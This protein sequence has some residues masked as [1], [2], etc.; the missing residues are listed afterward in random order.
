MK[1]DDVD[2]LDLLEKAIVSMNLLQFRF[3][4]DRQ[5]DYD[6]MDWFIANGELRVY[7][8]GNYF[9][10][11]LV[12]KNKLNL[13]IGYAYA[14]CNDRNIENTNNCSVQNTYLN[15]IWRKTGKFVYCTSNLLN[16][17]EEVKLLFGGNDSYTF[18]NS[19]ENYKSIESNSKK[20]LSIL[21]TLESVHFLNS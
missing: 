6:L 1:K 12:T 5:Y 11:N 17:P 3:G 14:G 7:K 10:L 9:C 19:S 4:K 18:S 13:L 2:N 8:K 21:N 16:T 20:L 15:Y